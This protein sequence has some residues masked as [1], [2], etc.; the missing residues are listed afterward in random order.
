MALFI[1]AF[2]QTVVVHRL[3]DSITEITLLPLFFRYA[4]SAD[5]VKRLMKMRD[6]GLLPYSIILDVEL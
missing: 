4:L 3:S 2:F 5:V 6:R 1:K